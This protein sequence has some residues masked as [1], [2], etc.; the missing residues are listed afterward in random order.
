[1]GCN[2]YATPK[3]TKELKNKIKEQIDTDQI[4]RARKLIPERVHVGKSSAG[5]QFLF[6]HN[7]WEYFDK[8]L[9]S[10]EAFLM[11]C[12]IEDEYGEPISY[13]DFWDMVDAK[14]HLIDGKE[15]YVN[16]DE[17][18]KDYKTGKPYPRPSY[19]P[20]DYGEEIH[21]GLRF[22]TYTDFL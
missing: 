4:G 8:S 20:N 9:E 7:N 14:K 10:L 18:N 12:D 1:M 2:Y 22:S 16:W 5:W 19:I 11:A 3:L 17:H 15:Y 13:K 6:N 21:F